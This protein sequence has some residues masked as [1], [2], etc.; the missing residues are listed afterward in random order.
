MNLLLL[1]VPIGI[2]LILFAVGVGVGRLALRPWR[3][4]YESSLEFHCFAAGIGM[5][6]L[7]HCTLVLGLL[8]GW[9]AGGFAG[10]GIVLAGA[11]VVGFWPVRQRAPGSHPQAEE[12]LNQRPTVVNLIALAT[13]VVIVVYLGLLATLP[14]A[15]YD[16]LE[17]HVGAVQHGLRQGRIFSFPHLFYA[18]LPFE[19]EMWNAPACFLEGNPLFPATPK[20]INF[21]LL[22]CT[23]ATVY[24]LASKLC[25]QR[26]L[27]LLAC[28]IFAIHP[29]TW[30][31]MLDGLNDLGPT[32]YAALAVVAWLNWAS[33][34]GAVFF[35]LWAV[36]LGLAV[37]CKYTAVGI[38]VFPMAVILLPVA[39]LIRQS[40]GVEKHDPSFAGM[41]AGT[42]TGAG[43]LGPRSFAGRLVGGW[44]LIG[45]IIAAVFL[46]WALKNVVQHG[47]PVYPLLSGLFPS[48]T[49]SPEQ[50]QYYLAAH[51]KTNPVH[52]AYWRA[53]ADNFG[54]LGVW[55]V[56]AV[57]IG[58]FLKGA[59]TTARAF[60]GT[61]ALGIA[62]HSLLPGNPTRFMLPLLP[63]AV[64]LAARLAEQAY[65]LAP[66][67]RGAVVAPFILWVG[68]AA[69]TSLGLITM[70]GPWT[71]NFG[72]LGLPIM[73]ESPNAGGV[74]SYLL[75]RVSRYFMLSGALGDDVIRSQRFIN[76][77]TPPGSRIFLLYEARI[78]CFARPVEVGSAFDRSPLVARAVGSR[79]GRELLERLRGEGFD[80]LY[81]NEFELVRILR[82]YGPRPLY[83][84]RVAALGQPDVRN[85]A[86]WLDLYPP[87]Y[88]DPRFPDC[89]RVIEEFLEIC[90]Q[91]AVYTIAPGVPFGI[92]IAQ[93]GG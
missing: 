63:V 9:R 14:P 44:L 5:A 83:A 51:G 7:S 50:T 91:Q 54:R 12:S 65:R 29:L 36:T 25:R 62:V 82:S 40:A 20:L 93:L 73:S 16:V 17:Y 8:G 24:V 72:V 4:Q 89:R 49:W 19:V 37:C 61:I 6:V 43:G 70:K 47:N 57:A 15:N 84:E 46:P 1:L 33:G 48:P 58:S 71:A 34:R 68:L 32:L 23:L 88:E 76:E 66:P 87:F 27:P 67:L 56:A 28:L 13:L 78:G 2:T 74:L 77:Q 52:P 41:K 31:V 79:S 55:L 53:L 39:L 38:T 18:S 3:R 11:A 35:V 80:Y 69:M 92:W 90:R 45:A 75:S 26:G 86:P 59:G 85:V 42:E 81:V 10:A 64:A 60:A 21:G 22:V 30:V